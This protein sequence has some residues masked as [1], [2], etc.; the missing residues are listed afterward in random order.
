MRKKKLAQ[1]AE[2]L[3]VLGTPLAERLEGENGEFKI[4]QRHRG[5]LEQ[6]IGV[7]VEGIVLQG[8]FGKLQR[9]HR[10]FPENLR[11]LEAQRGKPAKEVLFA[12]GQVD[13]RAAQKL[14]SLKELRRLF[15]HGLQ[16]GHGIAKITDFHRAD[17]FE[18]VVAGV[19]GEVFISLQGHTGRMGERVK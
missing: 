17:R 4:P 19:I 18:P 8:L 10:V 1:F 16:E 5:V 3:R 6:M 9:G 14:A 13:L 12:F 2:H 15:E 7:V 11:P